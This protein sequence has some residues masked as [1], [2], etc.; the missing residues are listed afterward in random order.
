MGK[1]VKLF[2]VSRGS[3]LPA[4]NVDSA[5]IQI[6]KYAE[7]PWHVQDE[8]LFFRMIKA[9]FSQRR[10]QLAGVLAG[11]FAISKS[12]M[13]VIFDQAGLSPSVRIESLSMQ[14]LVNLSDQFI[15]GC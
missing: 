14:E 3:F 8:A 2:D 5:V 4:P 11:A 15:R 10:K 1:A 13:H 12:E 9:G 7:N 6:Q